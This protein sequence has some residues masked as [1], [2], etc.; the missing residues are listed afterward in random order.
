MN[1]IFVATAFL[2]VEKFAF[3][4]ATVVSYCTVETNGFKVR[5]NKYK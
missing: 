5:D 4:V 1:K 3:N 2:V